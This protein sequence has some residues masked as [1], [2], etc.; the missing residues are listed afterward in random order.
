MVTRQKSGL[1]L[2]GSVAAFVAT[3]FVVGNCILL[4]AGAWNL[5]STQ[6]TL[7]GTFR[8]F[9]SVWFWLVPI[10]VAAALWLTAWRRRLLGAASFLLVWYPA[11]TIVLA[12]TVVVFYERLLSELAPLPPL[13]FVAN[14][15]LIVGLMVIQAATT[16][17]CA[18][19]IATAEPGNAR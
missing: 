12:V 8:H 9:P 17:R 10:P 14:A 7:V 1:T 5:W 19:L 13:Q 18:W 3:L 15:V 16:I 6:L 4:L 11:L 2:L